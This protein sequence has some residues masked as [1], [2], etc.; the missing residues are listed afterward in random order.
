MKMANNFPLTEKWMPGLDIET[1]S[2]NQAVVLA[3]DLEAELAKGEVLS[4]YHA[5]DGIHEWK[6]HKQMGDT[7]EALLI[8]AREI[9][10]ETA[11]DLLRE[12]FAA[13]E[14][15]PDNESIQRFH[16]MRDRV[17]AFLSRE[18]AK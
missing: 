13:S 14:A 2:W 17:R 18:E 10:A 11:E 8:G 3:A 12:F 16:D 7:H 1:N 6:T 15:R 5:Q 4:A 9:R